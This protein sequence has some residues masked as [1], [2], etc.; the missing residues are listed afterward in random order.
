MADPWQ[1]AVNLHRAVEEGLRL[2][3]L[4]R[5]P[6]RYEDY[7]GAKETVRKLWL[8]EWRPG[9]HKP[10]KDG[11][12]PAYLLLGFL[13]GYFFYR[14]LPENDLAFWPDF[15]KALGLDQQE[16]TPAQRDLLWGVLYG[17]PLVQRHLRFQADGSRDFVGTLDAL[18]GFRALR[19][20]DLLAHL[21]RYR[22]EGVLAGELG[23]YGEILSTL[24]EA[25]DR[26]AQE[27][28]A[29]EELE[30]LEGLVARLEGLGFFP[31]DPHPLRFLF[32]RSQEALRSLYR[33][34]RGEKS[35][36]VR[37]SKV[38]VE[39]LQGKGLVERVVPQMRPEPLLE[40]MKVY[41][42]VRFRDGT[43]QGFIWT[44]R[45]DERGLPIPEEKRL[46]HQEGEVVFRLHHR[47]WGVRF[48]DSF[49]NPV[50]FWR[51]PEPFR[52]ESFHFDPA[53]NPLAFSLESG[54]APVEDPWGISLDQ[55]LLEDV[56]LVEVL[57]SGKRE[58]GEWRLLGR[59]PVRFHPVLTPRLT[60]EA[61]ELGLS[62]PGELEVELLPSQA[63][64]QRARGSVR[65]PRGR[66]PF[67]VR[68][69]A[70]GQVWEYEVP[71]RGWPAAF[72]RA[73]M[74]FGNLGP[75][76]PEGPV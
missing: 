72:Y 5:A 16:P 43:F 41:G 68:V 40:G 31:P 61:L 1:H 38:R 74:A 37:Y 60:E 45:L 27:E 9:L 24:K 63:P 46:M 59:L 53:K 10:T 42:R 29:E 7:L 67:R 62:P 32:H 47:A 25:L 4:R 20:R 15:L 17:V 50:P 34:W 19:L 56:L 44:P 26:L 55:A 58:H 57:V 35:E 51:Y 22:E 49:G 2:G 69:Q 52:V 76:R 21:R 70:F 8:G 6:V 71:P 48:L 18:F 39:L 66:L 14:N 54:G 65:I 28:L 11:V 30:D 23:A 75:L 36:A 33:E 13:A 73:G 64:P 12:V 3:D